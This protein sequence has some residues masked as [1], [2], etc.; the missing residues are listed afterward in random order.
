MDIQDKNECYNVDQS[1]YRYANNFVHKRL[2]VDLP[3][4]ILTS[5]IGLGKMGDKSLGAPLAVVRHADG[6]HFLPL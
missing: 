6:N 1:A 2:N 4:L 5:D 3:S